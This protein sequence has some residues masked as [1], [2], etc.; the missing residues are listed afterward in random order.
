M[1]AIVWEFV[2]KE[3]S[4]PEFR[5]VYG[6]SGDWADLFRQYPGFAG[7]T[8]LQDRAARTRFLTI[9]HWQ[10]AGQF[11]QMRERSQGEYARLDAA[12]G[13]LTVSEREVGVFDVA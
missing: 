8:L 11:N 10:D 2:V 1:I 12:C 9:D 13:A 4:V 3:E 5:R 6:P 7:T